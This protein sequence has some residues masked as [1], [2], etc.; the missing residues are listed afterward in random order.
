M[1][2]TL[3]A[4][5][6]VALLAAACTGADPDPGPSLPP[7]PAGVSSDPDWLPDTPDSA[8]LSEPVVARGTVTTADGSRVVDAQVM[9]VVWPEPEVLDT[10]DEGDPVPLTPVAKAR[11]GPDG[12][13]ELR[14]AAEARSGLTIDADGIVDYQVSAETAD[15]YADFQ[16]SGP[17]ELTH[18]QTADLELAEKSR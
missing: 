11:T 16:W 10:L 6:V 12:G 7:S 2:R 8:E 4:V 13:Y 18:P 17:P 14:I 5:A 15:G 3:V 1:P 9:L